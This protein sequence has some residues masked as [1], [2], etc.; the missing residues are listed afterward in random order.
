MKNSKTKITF[1]FVLFAFQ[2]L[3]AAK[4]PQ[5]IML[6]NPLK[7]DR[8]DE[9]FI[10]KRNQLTDNI[11]SLLP[12]LKDKNGKHISCQVDDIN[13]D[14]EWDE[15]AFV[16]NLKALER[17][18][19]TIE[20]VKKD[21]YP[22]FQKRTNVRFGKM[23]SPGKVVGLL[24]DSHGKY[25][26]PRG[27]GYP[28]QM[29]GPAWEN[30]I[31]GFR[32]YFDGRNCRDFFGKKTTSMVLD[33]VG[34]RADGTPGDTYHIMAEWGRD[35]MSV[36]SSFGLGGLAILT[37]DTLLRLGVAIS[38]TTDN[39]DSTRF[40]QLVNG[41]I[42]SMFR[43]DF[44]GWDVQG[45][46]VNLS[47]TISIWAGKYGY[48]NIVTTSKLPPNS[49]LVTGIVNNNNNQ[50]QIESHDNP[51]FVSMITHDKQTYDK[52]WYMGMSLVIPTANF[53][54]GFEAPKQNS[55]II[56]TWCAKL[57]PDKAQTYSYNVYG[58][59]ELQNSKIR[60]REY[61]VGLIQNEITKLSSPVK[62]VLK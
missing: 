29:D 8:V 11:T 18:E 43:L 26:L 28:Y 36:A 51:L 2:L 4:R 23:V 41:V 9:Q 38:K 53:V 21:Q 3:F 17:K 22:E 55:D 24:T 60:N 61:F 34:I 57:K 46:K 54:S 14:G 48:E 25:N 40:T 5:T 31:V 27:A 13:A 42:R 59:W 44:Y 45:T 32:H 12:I 33:T 10:V 1:F 30:D 39:V 56:T 20:W 35:V 58:A 49:Y 15:L 7:I 62:I 47:A 37:P 16:C 50:P 52:V 19:I 6:T